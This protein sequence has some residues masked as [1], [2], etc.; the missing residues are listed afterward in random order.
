MPAAF[1]DIAVR[2]FATHRA[3][4]APVGATNLRPGDLVKFSSNLL[5]PAADNDEN[6]QLYSVLEGALAS[7]TTNGALV[8]PFAD[9]LMD[10]DYTG[11]TPTV[12]TDYG[13]SDQRTVDVANTTQLVVTVVAVDTDRNVVTVKEF[14]QSA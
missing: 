3:F 1:A 9:C 10:L 11:G 2:S 7:N 13:I 12:G 14:Q 6:I 4:R 8:V 5:V